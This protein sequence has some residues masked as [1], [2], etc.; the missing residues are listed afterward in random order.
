M[1]TVQDCLAMCELTEEE[2]RAIAQHEHI[3]EVVAAEL[4]NYLVHSA[5]GE[6]MIKRMIVDD[7]EEAREA[8]N[9]RRAAEL[10]LVL[11]HFAETHA[12]PPA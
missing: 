3:P 7:I 4:G 8:G 12:H 1:L 11:K 5:S 6:R 9:A 2:V 10:K